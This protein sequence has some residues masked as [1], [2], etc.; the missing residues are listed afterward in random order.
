MFKS[1]LRSAWRNLIKQRS[2]SLINIAGL[3]IG[4]TVCFIIV[5]Y[6]QEELGYDRFNE[7][8]GRIYRVAFRAN[9]NGGKINEA[10][11]MPPVA[12]AMKRDFPEV[13]DATRLVARGIAAISYQDKK[14]KEDRFALIDPNFFNVFTLKFI[15]GDATSAL[16]QPN[17]VVISQKTA[18]RI[19][20]NEEAVGKLININNSPEPYQVM[21]V[22]ENLPENSHYKFDVFGSTASLPDSRSDS[23]LRS[24]FFTYLLLRQGADAEKLEQK[25]PAMIEKYMGPQIIQQMGMSLSQFRTKGNE[26]GFTLQP[27]TAIHLHSHSNFELEPSGN[28]MYIYVFTA[29]GIFMLFIACINFINLSTANASKRAKEIGI[30]KVV[31]SERKQL[32]IQ[33]L[34]ES[35]VLVGIT[36]LVALVLIQLFLPVFNQFYDKNFELAFDMKVISAL[37]GLGLVVTIGSGLYPALY[38]SSFRPIAVLK[39]KFNESQ[40]S[41]SVRSVLVVLQFVISVTLIIC[42]LTVQQQ[43]Q[44]VQQ[45]Q[46]GYDKEAVLVVSN[47]YVLGQNERVFRDVMTKDSRVL[48]STISSYKP[49][50]PSGNNNAL[51]YPEG[52]E[53]QLMKTIEY[54]VDEAYVPTL[55]MQIVAGRN[56]SAAHPTDSMGLLINETAARSFGW[57]PNDAVGKMIV[58][59]NSHRGTNVPFRVV[60]VVKD[61]NFKSLH[62]PITPLLMTLHP[63]SGL[64]FKVNT[65]DIQGLIADMKKQWASFSPEEA[66]DFEFLDDLYNRTYAAEQK[67]GNILNVFTLVTIL[68]A[69]LGLFGLATYIAEQRTKE[70]GVRKVLGASVLQITGML[71]AHLLRLVFIAG[72]IAFPVSYF[73]MTRWLENFAYRISFQWEVLAIA[74]IGAL[75]VALITVSFQTVRAAQANPVKTLRSE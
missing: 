7:H 68:V 1:Y 15:K 60:G 64:I 58:R 23:W 43:M 61:F 9:I 65:A 63:E 72:V 17:Y 29:V 13:E 12:A 70:I 59:Q 21:G 75:L 55:G 71:S 50:G 47:S 31:G 32:V 39:G 20:G 42:T 44:Y 10:N 34:F 53:N 8:A 52:N 16:S 36:L 11:V 37:L 19:F 51:A 35:A 49:A 67:T 45:K 22:V 62:E 46:L 40:K 48:R 4:I 28:I 57:Q 66:L 38:I 33:F 5:M 6:V 26:L 27:L 54:H 74:M 56:F 14:F 18:S 24:D 69:C 30:R 2:Y 73:V 25:F 3:S 41:F